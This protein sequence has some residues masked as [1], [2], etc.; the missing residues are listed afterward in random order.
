[1]EAFLQGARIVDVDPKGDHALDR[2]PGVSAELEAIELH[3]APRYR[4]LL[5]PLSIAPAGTEEDFA[6][7]FLIDVLPHPVPPA[8]RTELRR[9]VKAVV[10]GAGS[11][12]ANCCCVIAI[13]LAGDDVA[14]EVGRA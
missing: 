1:Y 2:L 6:T 5:D 8:W 13:L 11:A 7:S 9:A 12:G 14:V 4:G 10:A 3:A